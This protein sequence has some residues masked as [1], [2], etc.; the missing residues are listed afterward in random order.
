M[1]CNSGNPVEFQKGLSPRSGRTKIAQRFSAGKAAIK[2]KIKPVKW[3]TEVTEPGAVATGSQT[4]R[5]WLH[6]LA[7]ARG[8]VPI[9]RPLCG[10]QNLFLRF[11]P[12][13][14]ALGYCRS[15]AARTP[16]IPTALSPSTARLQVRAG[17]PDRPLVAVAADSRLTFPA[18]RR[19]LR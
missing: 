10:L 8:S 4:Q 18:R 19:R 15:S 3:A 11:F 14:E 16:A 7:T 17:A 12:S 5:E 1:K 6:P 9:C 13:A 2:H